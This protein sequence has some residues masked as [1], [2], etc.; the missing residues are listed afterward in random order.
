[1]RVINDP[2]GIL[3]DGVRHMLLQLFEVE[4]FAVTEDGKH[5]I[6]QAVFIPEVWVWEYKL[7]R[8]TKHVV[9]NNGNTVG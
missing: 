3:P 6:Y 1:M 4:G 9:G 8:E 5:I 7:E 2:D